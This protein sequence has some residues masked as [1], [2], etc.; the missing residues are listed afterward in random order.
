MFGSSLYQVGLNAVINFLQIPLIDVLKVPS[1][2]GTMR[3]CVLYSRTDMSFTICPSKQLKPGGG[4]V[5]RVKD[6]PRTESIEQ[7]IGQLR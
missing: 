6:D 1:L 7:C 3:K 4:Q 5:L 2:F